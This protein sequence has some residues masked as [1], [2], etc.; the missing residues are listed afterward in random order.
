MLCYVMLCY[1]MLCYV[2]LCYV[3]LRYPTKVSKPHADVVHSNVTLHIAG[4]KSQ[5]SQKCRMDILWY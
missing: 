3:M 5:A 1:V 4:F 2:M